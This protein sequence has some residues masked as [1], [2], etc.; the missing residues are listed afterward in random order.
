[1]VEKW[2]DDDES[3]TLE[4][5]AFVWIRTRYNLN[6]TWA[7]LYL[8]NKRFYAKDRLT[9]LKIVDPSFSEL[10]EIT[11]DV[12]NLII[13]GAQGG[14]QFTLKIKMKDID[15]TWEWMLRQKI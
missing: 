6:G 13:S 3:I 4:G 2:L 14:K 10:S 5:K 1:M 12:K 9:G 8:T 11:S 7:L 15:D